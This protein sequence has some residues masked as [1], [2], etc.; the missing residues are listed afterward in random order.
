MN[1]FG[2]IGY[3][4]GHSFSKNFFNQKFQSE[5]ID[6]EY[7]N[8]E[9]PTIGELPNILLSNPDL[10]GLNVTIPYKQ[11]IMPLLDDIDAV[12][13]AI[14]AVNVIRIERSDDVVRM[15]GYNSDYIGFRN[16]ITPLL[17]P[18]HTHALVL[19]TG[20]AAKAV[21]AAL[22][23]M[24]ILVKRVSR[25]PREGELSYDNLTVDVIAQHT[26]VVNTTPLGMFPH[27][28]ACAPIPYE[29]LTSRHLCYDVVYNP[30]TTLFMK[31]ASE[32]GAT[33]CNG[34][35]MLYGQADAAWD[36]WNKQMV[37]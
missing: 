33:V 34:L 10:V 15:V 35:A 21:C 32:Q 2:L 1:K 31:R 18:H 29:L 7:V 24:G 8:F 26:I 17:K 9:I 13:Q 27:V 20:G 28:D 14:G 23:D 36:I 12:A 16:S 6:A 3:P 37:K 25:T 22:S 4:L 19:G 5:N 11:S 30:A